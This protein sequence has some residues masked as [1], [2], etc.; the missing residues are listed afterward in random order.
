MTD[1]RKRLLTALAGVAKAPDGPALRKA[2]GEA[3][4]GEFYAEVTL[5]EIEGYVISKPV[6]V[7]AARGGS[8]LRTYEL[9]AR[10]RALANNIGGL[11]P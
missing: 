2:T 7:R 5:L 3:P 9:T 11:R 1:L 10:G 4:K 8:D 6:A